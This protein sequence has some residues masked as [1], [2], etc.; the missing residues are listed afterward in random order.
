[1]PDAV[2]LYTIGH[3]TRSLAEF[4]AMLEGPHVDFIADVRRFPRSRRHPQFNGDALA[5]SLAERTIAYRHF[6]ALGGRRQGRGALSPHT[7][8]REEMFRNY[9]DYAETPEFRA[10]LSS[11]LEL[12]ARH[13]VAILCAEAVWW[14]CHRRIVADYCIAA[15]AAVTHILDKDKLVPAQLTEGA[16]V[17][18]DAGVLYAGAQSALPL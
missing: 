8:W 2:S 12:A 5:A 13:R 16:Q 15:G 6:E 18:G 10:S 11:L 17:R 3:S 1:M 9:A 14:R 4:C 7:L